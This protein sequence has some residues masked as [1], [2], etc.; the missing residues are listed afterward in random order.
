MQTPKRVVVFPNGMVMAFDAAG[1]QIPELQGPLPDVW[2]ALWAAGVREVETG[3]WNRGDPYS[4]G[5]VALAALKSSAWGKER[6][7]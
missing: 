4:S 7:G 2:A 5:H 1:Q 3:S 6:P